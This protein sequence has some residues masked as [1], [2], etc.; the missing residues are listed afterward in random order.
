[1]NVDPELPKEPRP[2]KY[3]TLNGRRVP[4]ERGDNILRN[5]RV[6][7]DCWEWTGSRSFWGYG[8]A[9]MDGKPYRA[10]RASYL[11]FVGEIPEGMFVLH[12][13][14]N[15]ACVRPSHL[16]VG[17]LSDNAQD[18]ARKGRS[19]AQRHPRS[20]VR[21]VPPE[22]RSRGTKRPSAK[23]NDAAVIEIRGL[24]AS[25]T[26]MRQIALRY[27]VS[28]QIIRR[29]RNGEGW[30]HVPQTAELVLTPAPPPASAAEAEA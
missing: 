10:H 16:F 14:D 27:G 30:K 19:G 6:V 15:P 24:L 11:V 29:I 3:K 22:R 21:Y 4:G 20:M 23:L 13:C 5:V 25:G 17:T 1:M 28:H 8:T 7:G 2:L 18:C 12:K 9:Y 26:S